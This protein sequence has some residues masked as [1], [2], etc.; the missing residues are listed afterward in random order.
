MFKKVIMSVMLLVVLVLTACSEE[1]T[2][3]NKEVTVDAFQSMMEM[4]KYEATSS[5]DVNVE[6]EVQDPFIQPY[7]QMVN[8]MELSVDQRVDMTKNLQE[9]VVHFSAQMNP[10][11]FNVDLPILQ[12]IEDQTMY[13]ETDSL[14]ENFGMMLGLSEDLSGKLLKIDLAELEGAETEA[15]DYQEIQEKAQTM[16]TDFLQDKSE[17]DFT[18]DGETY[19]VTFTKE[20]LTDFVAQM[21]TEFDDTI[22]DEELQQGI[23]EMNTALEEVDLNTFEVHVT[24]DGDQIKS[25]KFVLDTAF[26]AEGTPVQLNLEAD[27]T[28]NSIGEDIEFTIDPENSE[29]LEMSEFEQMMMGGMGY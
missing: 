9:M 13:I 8:D 3:S 7:I 6:A 17:E 23:D 11:S 22:S 19:I 20:E 28:Y 16:M 26:D 2:R 12:N 15:L 25:Q 24:M 18:K 10:M 27:T 1:E 21:V 14:V 4:E 5:L 29:I